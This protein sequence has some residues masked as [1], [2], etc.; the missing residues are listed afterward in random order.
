ME[1]PDGPN[2]KFCNPCGINCSNYEAEAAAIKTATELIHQKLE[3]KEKEPANIIIFS[4]SMSV[5]EALKSQSY[6]NSEIRKT[7]QAIHNLIEAY[8]IQITLQWIPGHC[9]LPGN[10]IADSL[11]KAGASQQQEDRPCSQ[12]TIKSIL[13]NNSKEEWLNRWATGLTGR[14]MYNEM[15][16]PNPKDSINRLSRR[17]QSLI[18]QFRT[19]HARTNAYKNRWDSMHPPLC[20]HC[21]YHMESTTHLL[22]DCLKLNT[23]RK[24][25]LPENPTIHNTL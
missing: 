5:L 8:H 10:E 12:R 7:A 20:R 24:D 19:Q 3:L 2:Q 23:V 16:R 21:Q 6:E 4:D 11:A 25:L 22:C 15:K 17:E 9:G 18:F 13:R 14:A 1:F